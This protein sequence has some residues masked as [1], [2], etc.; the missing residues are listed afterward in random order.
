[1]CPIDQEVTNMFTNDLSTNYIVFELK[2]ELTKSQSDAQVPSELDPMQ[3][4][5][6]LT[7]P[8][9]TGVF[10]CI[11]HQKAL[12]FICV[13]CKELTC[14]KCL[15]LG[16]HKGHEPCELNSPQAN[17]LLDKKVNILMEKLNYLQ[18]KIEF[19]IEDSKKKLNL[20]KS[21]Y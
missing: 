5:R 4:Q 1:M 19:Q 9:Q 11:L 14:S 20:C 13:E 16:K 2:Q 6:T 18:N 15:L 10:P 17:A 21:S 12:E 8:Q 3:L 7:G